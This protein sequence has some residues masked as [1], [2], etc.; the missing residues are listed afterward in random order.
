VDWSAICIRKSTGSNGPPR[1]S[2]N[3]T[4]DMTL[5]LAPRSK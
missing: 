4:F 2:S 1:T 5:M 3:V